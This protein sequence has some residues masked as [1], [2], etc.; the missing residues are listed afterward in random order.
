MLACV[1][2]ELVTQAK[3][4]SSNSTAATQQQQ[5][6]S[7]NSTAATQQQRLISTT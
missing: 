4:S 2:K 5:L 7:S 6:N 3:L 1:L